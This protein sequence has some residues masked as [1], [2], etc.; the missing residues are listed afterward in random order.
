MS[1]VQYEIK[2]ISPSEAAEMLS[3]KRSAVSIKP[4]RVR[5][6]ADEMR[7][8]RWVLN[9]D[10]IILGKSG[11]LLAGAQRLEACVSAQSSFPALL[12]SNVEDDAFETIDAV[13]RRTVSDILSIRK[14]ASGRVLAASLNILWKYSSGNY[15]KGGKS[16]S[17][18]MLLAVLAEHPDLRASVS[19]TTGLSSILP[20]AV[21]AAL[22]YL[23]SRVDADAAVRFFSDLRNH[24]PQQTSVA[25]LRRQL[26]NLAEMG[27]SKRQPHLIG[28]T[29]K[30]WEAF[31]LDAE[32]KLLRYDPDTDE[33]PEIS[34][35]SVA[36][37]EAGLNVSIER[38]GLSQEKIINEIEVE[39]V[40][41]TPDLAESLLEK[42][43]LNRNVA[44]YVV[45][46]YAR[47]MSAGEWK[48]NGQTIKIA[49]TGR[50][51]DGQHRLQAS[52]KSGQSF[53]GMIVRGLD[54][55]VFETF[56]LGARRSLA[57]I[58]KDRGEINTSTLAAAL[59]QLWLLE[60][61]FLTSKMATPT[62][63]EMLDTLERSPT[64]RD[65]VRYAGQ[66]K[67]ITAPSLVVAL[68]HQFAQKSKSHADLFIQRLADGAELPAKN[69]ILRL[70]DQLMRAKAERKNVMAD[71]ERAAWVIKAWNAY[72]DGR[73]IAHIKWA[74]NGPR[75]ESFP[76]IKGPRLRS[77][78]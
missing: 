11:D 68:H 31:R 69:P 37:F 40:D 8:G 63:A 29:I 26:V 55:K 5:Q 28:L 16:P 20:H 49:S 47:D 76:V 53:P 12:V 4:E 46:K 59:R 19:L 43:T 54:E 66:I 9:G 73:E 75:G 7:H 57:D 34:D 61:G 44:S 39:V 3:S 74:P 13:R 72:I 62:V 27:G 35:F 71:P 2:D 51:L 42:N 58:L 45:D 38:S 6:Y 52:I 41:I 65:S 23:F 18:Q 50:L 77:A 10:P 25:A 15:V 17:P 64:L 67:H 30:A 36:G 56:D 32:V 78:A 22:H 60:N 70:R 14:E 48:L 33:Q 1:N 21:A 24:E